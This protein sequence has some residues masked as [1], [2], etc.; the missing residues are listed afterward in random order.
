MIATFEP[1]SRKHFY[2]LTDLTVHQSYDSSY[3][4]VTD[5]P[6]IERDASL[7]IIGMV[8]WESIDAKVNFAITYALLHH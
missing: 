4:V 1:A 2:D 6:R 5:P 8:Q 3:A 7:Y